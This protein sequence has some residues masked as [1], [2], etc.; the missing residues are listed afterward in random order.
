LL[1]QYDPSVKGELATVMKARRDSDPEILSQKD[2]HR[3]FRM[4]RKLVETVFDKCERN[5]NLLSRE[6]SRRIGMSNTTSK[7][8]RYMP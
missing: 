7:H 6:L 4:Y 3:E 2:K 5:A 8:N 1:D